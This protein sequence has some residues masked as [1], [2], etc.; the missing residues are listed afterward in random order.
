[1]PLLARELCRVCDVD[2]SQDLTETRYGY[3]E[4]PRLEVLHMRI[5]MVFRPE[6]MS[7]AHHSLTVNTGA[8]VGMQ[9]GSWGRGGC[10]R[11]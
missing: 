1:M 10:E 11:T 4:V 9:G 3:V 5:S 8:P 6:R 2:L 7:E